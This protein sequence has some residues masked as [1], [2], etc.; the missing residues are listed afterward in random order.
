V[1]INIQ[2]TDVGVFL[3]SDTVRVNCFT[4]F[5]TVTAGLI[6]KRIVWVSGDMTN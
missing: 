4:V 5:K 3:S 6:E 2:P 1:L